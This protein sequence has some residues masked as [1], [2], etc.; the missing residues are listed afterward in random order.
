MESSIFLSQSAFSS[1]VLPNV[2]TEQQTYKV[3]YNILKQLM[4][5]RIHIINKNIPN[6]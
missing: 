3:S 6:L 5:I 1:E 4:I 2:H